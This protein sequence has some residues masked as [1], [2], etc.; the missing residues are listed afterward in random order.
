M[1]IFFCNYIILSNDYKKNNLQIL[2]IIF[3]VI[4]LLII[5]R[6]TGTC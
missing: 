4:M 1:Q 6:P 3:F 5:E 2:Q